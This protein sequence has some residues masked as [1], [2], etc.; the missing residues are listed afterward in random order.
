MSLVCHVRHGACAAVTTAEARNSV[1][2]RLDPRRHE[3]S[4]CG[5]GCCLPQGE[6]R[7]NRNNDNNSNMFLTNHH[8]QRC[9][10]YRHCHGY[11][12]NRWWCYY[13]CWCLF[14]PSAIRYVAIH[15]GNKC[16]YKHACMSRYV[17]FWLHFQYMGMYI[18]ICKT[19]C[20][21]TAP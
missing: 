10:D 5:L 7:S 12:F 1:A 8:Y 4:T 11:H 15:T 13:C 3:K 16:T 2:S 17:Y 9:Y 19:K 21:R 20:Q 14:C 6:H 18:C